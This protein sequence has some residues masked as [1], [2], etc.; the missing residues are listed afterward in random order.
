MAEVK[1]DD[2]KQVT[3]KDI[4]A[5]QMDIEQ[6]GYKAQQDDERQGNSMRQ[7]VKSLE[8]STRLNIE[9]LENRIDS[10]EHRTAM[11]LGA[12][13]AAGIAVVVV[14]VAVS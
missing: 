9:R 10:L 13:M 4:K 5:L 8:A 1:D 2:L 14:A 12:L 7:D 11:Q 3:L 6:L